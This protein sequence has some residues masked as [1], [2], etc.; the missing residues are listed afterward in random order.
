MKISIITTTYND[1]KNLET[2]IERVKKQD[3]PD[4]EHIIIDGGS[5]DGTLEIIEAYKK[6]QPERVRYISEKDHGIYDAINKGIK[7]ASGDIIGCCFDEYTGNDVLSKIAHTIEKEKTDGVHADLCYVQDGKVVRYWKQG[8]GKI[9]DGWLPAHPTLY[10]K[11][12]VYDQY[13]LYKTDYRISADYEFMIRILKDDKVKLS[14]INEILINMSYGGTS[15][16]GLKAYME[17]WK[18]GHRALKENNVSHPWVI[19]IKRILR[20]LKQFRNGKKI[21]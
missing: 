15:S 17:S 8:Q 16:N 20:V 14:Y 12:D 21:S 9:Q 10:L 5:T 13:G 6:E 11:K 18:E 19:D 3:Y 2:I 7:L 1:K 4:I